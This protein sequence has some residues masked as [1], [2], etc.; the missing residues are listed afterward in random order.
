MARTWLSYK[1]L[2]EKK[3]IHV[4]LSKR[5]AE[6]TKIS[7]MMLHRHSQTY[8]YSKI[9]RCL[10]H[11]CYSRNEVTIPKMRWLGIATR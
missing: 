10:I 1:V 4:R 9:M 3:K 11:A 2:A 7:S 6:I 5:N 8:S